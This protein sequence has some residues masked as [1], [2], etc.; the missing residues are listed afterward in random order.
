MKVGGG[1]AD[2]LPTILTSQNK[3]RQAKSK[4]VVG[5]VVMVCQILSHC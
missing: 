1:G 4:S 5:G 3:L 2:I